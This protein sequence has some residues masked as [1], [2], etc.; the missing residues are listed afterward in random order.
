M[1]KIKFDEVNHKYFLGK[2]ELLSVTT[3]LKKHGLATDF[4][5]VMISP[6]VLEEARNRGNKIHQ[7]VSEHIK[8][9]SPMTTKEAQQIA[10]WLEKF[11]QCEP[12]E[13]L[14][15]EYII[16]NNEIAGTID[17][18]LSLSSTKE[19]FFIADIKTG[20]VLDKIACSWQLSLY[21][22]LENKNYGKF[23]I[24]HTP[25]NKDLEVIE[26]PR[27]PKEEI[28]R[29]LECERNC[30]LYQPVQTELATVSKE[31]SAKI[32]LGI[33]TIKRIEKEV[34]EFKSAILSEMRDKNIKKFDN[35]EVSITYIAPIVRESIDT[36]K[37]KEELPE[38]AEKYKKVSNVKDSIKINIK[39]E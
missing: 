18:S 28:E 2:K 35:G 37:L 14:Q 19:Y 10:D 31:I 9:L 32:T 23:L 15:S 13:N 30:E 24:F 29:L 16:H 4:S 34:E 20:S 5:D 27:I 39:G 7:E 38:V 26:V 11:M 3:L 1:S 33:Q 12:N 21:E 25:K 8:K 36:K 17:L 6:A 22:Y